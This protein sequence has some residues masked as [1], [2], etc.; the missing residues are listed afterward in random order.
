MAP[1]AERMAR[2]LRANEISRSVVAPVARI[3]ITIG[4]SC[5]TNSSAGSR[6]NF[7]T[8]RS[9]LRTI[10]QIAQLGARGLLGSKCCPCPFGNQP[11]LFLS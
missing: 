1:R 5:F 4:K 8:E 3:A 2:A 10:S 9:G 11:T 6:L 7:P